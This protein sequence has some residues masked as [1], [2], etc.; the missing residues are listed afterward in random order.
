MENQ[1]KVLEFKIREFTKKFYLNKLIKGALFFILISLLSFILI[2]VSEYFSFFNSV[3][4][5]F[6]FYFYL[7]LAI[8][9]LC[10]C[11][12]MPLF[13]ILGFGKQLTKEEVAT[14]V[15]KHFKEIDDKFLN[16]IQLENQLDRGDYKSYQLLLAAIETKIETIKP[17]SFI[18]AIPFKKSFK[19]IKWA[20]IPVLLFIIIFT[21]KS[22]VFTDSTK[23]I[24]NYQQYFEKPAPYAFEIIESDLTVFQNEDCPIQIRTVGEEIPNEIYVTFGKHSFKCKKEE[25]NIFSYN[26][27]KLQKT[28]QFQITTDEVS[29]Q[30][31]EITVLPKPMIISFVMQLKYPSYLNKQTEEISNNGDASIPEG[32]TI[33]WK[34]YTKNSDLLLF[35]SDVIEKNINII[36]DNA[37]FTFNLKEDFKYQIVNRNQYCTSKDTLFHYISVIKDE[38]PQIV[39]DGQRDSLNVDR[40]YFKGNIRDDYGFTDLKFV[41]TKYNS[42]DKLLEQ[43]KIINIEIHKDVTIH[44]FYFFFDASKLQLNPGEKIEYYFE[45][46]DN[47]AIHGNKVA[48]STQQLFHVKT[49]EEI[50]KE[51]DQTSSEMKQEMKDLMKESSALM[52][53][54]EKLNQQVM[55]EQAPTWQDK[56][57]MEQLMEKFN[58]LKKQ[59]DQLQANQ[60]QQNKIEDQYKNLEE[61]IIQK[62]E[63]LQKRMEDILSDEMKNM[64]QQ[65]QEMMNKM[66]KDKMQEAMEKIKN[67][68]AEI[69]E[70]LDTQ[71]Q[72][73]KQL[74]YEKK[75]SEIVDKTRKLSEEQIKLSQEATEKNISKEELLNKQN[76]L[77]NQFEQVKD[78]IK[79]LQQLNK[80]L[81]EP[82]K[83]TNTEQLQKN[84]QQSMEESKESLQKNNKSKA[85]DKQKNAAN[86]LDQL[87]NQMENDMLDSQDEQL[88]E[89]IETVRQILDNL[90]AISFH[91][92]SNMLNINKI[93]VRSSAYTELM[94]EQSV[95]KEHFKMID[96]SLTAVARRQPEVKAF[97]LKEVN[98]INNYLATSQKTLIDRKT[99]EAQTNQQ[100]AL[101]SMNNLALMLSESITNMKKQQQECKNCKNGKKGKQGNCSKPGGNK[102]K[103]TSAK[104]LQQQLN[105]QMEALKRSMEQGKKEGE[106]SGQKPGE[107]NGNY[108]QELA[109]MAAQQ[110]AIRK[111]LQ[112]V[113]NESKKENGVGDRSLEQM[114]KDMEK[115]EKELVNRIISQ[116]TIKRQQSIETRLLESEKADLKREKEEKRESK[117]AT[118]IKNFAPPAEWKI[119]KNREAQNEMLK[120]VPVNLNYY[121]KNKVNQ[122]FFNIEEN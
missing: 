102:S 38:Y 66:D 50:E 47:D 51:L 17:F 53:E 1:L 2:T 70:Q 120:T 103:K 33:T 115:T 10:Y 8:S 37:N 41:Y 91:Q 87:A 104:E 90:I 85:A 48:R 89:D 46:R 94:R 54:I 101:T 5:G 42:D 29:S 72:L 100:F 18:K 86:Q 20:T 6:L 64:M 13:K 99:R 15:G 19:Y 52:K 107:G 63:E 16:I 24:I 49:M 110:E 45:V 84:I 95:I 119:D 31:Y 112:E 61:S 111:M 88:G 74:E 105:K 34:F 23:R 30:F 7:L 40:I 4:R 98:K 65:I 62:Q 93:G 77:E 39:V 118:E 35:S 44:D 22:E 96:D 73:Y 114:M 26:F 121:Y 71:L 9:T 32:T 109:K 57:K 113:Q 83:Q 59:L 122:Y 82:N 3:V 67:N 28:T 97:I 36:K 79:A 27:S 21:I 14:I 108:S 12:L 78:D 25:N 76:K 80:G 69:N 81:E 106:K 43:N 75:S 92:E 117:E 55:Q 68:A 56:K 116:E 60:K 58:A 11:V